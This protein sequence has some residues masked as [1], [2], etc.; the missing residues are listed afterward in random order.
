VGQRLRGLILIVVLASAG[1]LLGSSLSQWWTWTGGPAPPSALPGAP[2]RVKVQVLNAGGL[3]GAAREATRALRDRGFDVV[4]YGNAELFSHD[5]SAVLDRSGRLD[6]ARS[7]AEVLGIRTVRSEPD[8]SLFLDVT[9]RL[10]PEW[11]RPG[12]AEEK[13]GDPSPWWDLRRLLRRGAP[14]GANNPTG[15]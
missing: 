3:A 1:V 7:V 5:S 14:S 8:S 4:Y 11:V 12:T 15:P 9:V 2:G 13:L 6:R 10:G